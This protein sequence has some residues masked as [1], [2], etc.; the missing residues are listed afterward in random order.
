MP[1]NQERMVRRNVY[2]PDKLYTRFETYA[3]SHG[4]SSAEVIREAMRE[5]LERRDAAARQQLSMQVV[6]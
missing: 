2:L 6:P 3:H 4:I 5:Y 1:K